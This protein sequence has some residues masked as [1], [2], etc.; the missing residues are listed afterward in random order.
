MEDFDCRTLRTRDGRVIGVIPT[1][2]GPDWDGNFGVPRYEQCLLC[3]QDATGEAA[4]L[5][6]CFPVRG[7]PDYAALAM[8]DERLLIVHTACW[9]AV[10]RQL[11]AVHN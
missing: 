7:D 1:P 3:S 9:S 2:T 10:H 5:G 11:E 6:V 4:V 8:C